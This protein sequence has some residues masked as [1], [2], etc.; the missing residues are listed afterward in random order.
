[1]QEGRKRDYTLLEELLFRGFLSVPCRVGSTRLVL[2]TVNAG[3]ISRAELYAMPRSED[4]FDLRFTQYFVAH[5]IFLVGG[6]NLLPHRD[7]VIPVLADMVGSWHPVYVNE[8]VR[9][10]TSVQKSLGPL[11]EMVDVYSLESAS[12]FN[13]YLLGG[14]MPNDPAITG[15]SGTEKLGLNEAQRL[16]LFTN[17]MS[18][19][20]EDQESSWENTKFLAT[21]VNPKGMKKVHMRDQLRQEE[22]EAIRRRKL[23]LDPE[24]PNYV[25]TDRIETTE[26]L[27]RQLDKD[28]RGEKDAHDIYFE[29]YFQQED[30]ERAA[31]ME[32]LESLRESVAGKPSLSGQSSYITPEEMERRLELAKKR[33]SPETMEKALEVARRVQQIDGEY[34]PNRSI[35]AGR[36]RHHGSFSSPERF[37]TAE[38]EGRQAIDRDFGEPPPF[39]PES[40]NAGVGIGSSFMNPSKIEDL[41]MMDETRAEYG[42]KKSERIVA[43]APTKRPES[44]DDRYRRK[45]G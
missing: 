6:E 20:R 24:K 36:Y 25:L 10:V 5:S 43:R 17:R 23:G 39:M 14:V 8:I 40:Q 41:M 7:G 27:L 21:A 11:S 3:E 37:E 29:D 19:R 42:E 35:S 9:V 32:S 12:M 26:D 22:A 28:M 16:W 34:G 45:W 1:M 33:D 38:R 4:G 31:V 13:W 18:E 15:I 44:P 30:E 2:K